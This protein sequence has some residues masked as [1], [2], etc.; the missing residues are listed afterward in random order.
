MANE[1]ASSARY[2]AIFI[3]ILGVLRI[4]YG[5]AEH[6]YAPVVFGLIVAALIFACVLFLDWDRRRR[7]R[8]RE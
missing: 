7:E 5:L 1:S 2:V 4:L 3:L 8:E 6:Q